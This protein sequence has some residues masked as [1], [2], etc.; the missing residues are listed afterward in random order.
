MIGDILRRL[1]AEPEA[2]ASALSPEDCRL[3]LSALM[4]RL[5]RGDDH[6]SAEERAMIERIA[7]ERYG[8]DA[9]A[10][11]AL[12]EEAETLEAEAADTV[13]FT[14]LIKAAVPYEERSG[15]I[16]A[17]WRVAITDGIKAEEHGFI[18]MV[19]NLVGVSDVDSGLARQRVLRETGDA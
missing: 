1:R 14:R 7:R 3:A 6:Y 13:R 11:R 12:R 16:E 18:R 15:V 5:A 8:L 10:A 9:A 19:T 2:D 17:L 4:V